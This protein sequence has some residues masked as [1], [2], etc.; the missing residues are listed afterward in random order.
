MQISLG[1]ARSYYLSTAANDLGVVFA[2]S[3]DGE[4]LKPVSWEAMR[5]EGGLE[6]PR[7]VAGPSKS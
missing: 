5:T 6:E 3:S 1:D 4:Q 2:V 7:K